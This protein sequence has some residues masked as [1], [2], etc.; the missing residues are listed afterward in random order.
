[1][2][3]G[4]HWIE[5]AISTL[6]MLGT[7][8][9]FVG[10]FFFTYGR[11]S[12]RKVIDNQISILTKDL[13]SDFVFFANEASPQAL[14]ELQKNIGNVKLPDMTAADAA[15]TANNNKLIKEAVTMLSITFC[16]CLVIGISLWYFS[17]KKRGIKISSILVKTSFLMA[18]VMVVEFLFF[19]LVT[20]NFRPVDP[21]VVKTYF[22]DSLDK[23]AS[24]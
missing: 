4:T 19:T 21:N 22:I 1:M 17:G 23:Y 5:F 6:L 20:Q 16:V 13:T 8:A 2:A 24:S 12:E 3:L 9:A 11:Y 18:V 15:V 10:L 7:Y 14:K